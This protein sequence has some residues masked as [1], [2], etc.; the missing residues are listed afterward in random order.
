MQDFN[1]ATAIT[2]NTYQQIAGIY[3]ETYT[4]AHTPHFWHEWLQ[5][6]ASTVRAN[7]AYQANPSLL[8]V[9][10]GCG[11]GRD[12]LLLAQM[13]FT[14]LAVD[15]SEAML[16]EARQRCQGQPKAEH[17]LFRRMDMRS[18]NLPEAS[19]AGLWASASFLL[20]ALKS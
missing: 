14:V 17:I 6:F 5:R 12:S 20:S 2:M 8:I 13:D 15:L 16:A 3:A 18:L 11:P 7:P 10:V 19:C 1:D 9:D 4:L